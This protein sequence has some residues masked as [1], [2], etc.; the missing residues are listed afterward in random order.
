MSCTPEQYID[1]YGEPPPGLEGYAHHNGH[2]KGIKSGYQN[3]NQPTKEGFGPCFNNDECGSGQCV[4]KQAHLGGLGVCTV[5][6]ISGYQNPNKHHDGHHDGHHQVNNKLESST[7]E[8]Y[9]R[10]ST[11]DCGWPLPECEPGYHCSG[12]TFLGPPGHCK[13]NV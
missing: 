1:E 4:N 10:G 12:H 7:H 13:K 9:K 3:P 6:S 8:F 2:H 5:P 11:R